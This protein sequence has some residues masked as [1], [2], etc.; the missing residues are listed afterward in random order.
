MRSH[1]ATTINRH[2][3]QLKPRGSFVSDSQAD[4]SEQRNGACNI[5][6]KSQEE[7]NT[8]TGNFYDLSFLLPLKSLDLRKLALGFLFQDTSGSWGFPFCLGFPLK[9]KKTFSITR[10]RK[11]S[12]HI[13]ES[14][15][16]II[17]GALGIQHL[18]FT[19]KPNMV[20]SM[21]V[22]SLWIAAHNSLSFKGPPLASNFTGLSENQTA[23]LTSIAASENKHPS[24]FSTCSQST[25]QN[26]C[27]PNHKEDAH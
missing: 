27:L 11:E 24:M 5:I 6:S 15:N 7:Q 18:L 10:Q 4:I 1:S 19:A 3:W 8:V 9:K 22:S 23:S 21:A 20:C 13:S 12:Q 2:Q 17:I 14:D 16:N 26:I 25:Q